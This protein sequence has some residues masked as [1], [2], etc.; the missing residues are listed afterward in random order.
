M[1]V[2]V[3]NLT[4]AHP[5]LTKQGPHLEYPWEQGERVCHPSS[6]LPIVN[7]LRDANTLVA[8]HLLKFANHFVNNFDELF[9]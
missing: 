4:G 6:D 1:L 5:A 9:E 7:E 2:W 8:P 3:E